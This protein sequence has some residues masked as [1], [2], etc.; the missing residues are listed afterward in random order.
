MTTIARRRHGTKLVGRLTVYELRTALKFL[1]GQNN[2]TQAPEADSRQGILA[3]LHDLAHA[4]GKA[5]VDRLPPHRSYDLKIDL[6]EDFEP[7]FES[8]YK[9][10]REE[11]KAL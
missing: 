10:S 6:K 9:L 7:P 8:L 4:F 3:E 1:S 2:S 11:M 5:T